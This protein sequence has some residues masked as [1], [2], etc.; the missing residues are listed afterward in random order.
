MRVVV[1]ITM[2]A[3]AFSTPALADLNSAVNMVKRLPQVLDAVPDNAGSLWVKVLPIPGADYMGYA[4]SLCTAIVPHHGRIFLV[5]IVDGTSVK[6][7]KK[8]QDWRMLG[9]ANCGN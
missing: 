6:S 4:K 9:G 8:P 5:K 1:G 2:A 3:L 7:S